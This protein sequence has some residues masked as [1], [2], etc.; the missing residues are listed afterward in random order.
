MGGM[1]SK[2]FT[3]IILNNFRTYQEYNHH[4]TVENREPMNA[5]LEEVWIEVL[6]KSVLKVV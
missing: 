2:F 6:V 3:F 1:L 5:M 4:E